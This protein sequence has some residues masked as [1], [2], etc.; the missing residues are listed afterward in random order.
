MLTLN[1]YVVQ[2]VFSHVLKKLLLHLDELVQDF[3]DLL[4]IFCAV[5]RPVLEYMPAQYDTQI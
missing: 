1:N 4:C 3:E 5:I 2:L